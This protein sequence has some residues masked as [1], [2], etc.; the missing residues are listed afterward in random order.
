MVAV[1][2]DVV[3]VGQV[4]AARVDQ[5]D[6]RQVVLV[7]D[8]LR[9]QVLLDGDRV[10]G[11]ALDGGVVTDDH[12]LL[13]FDAADAGDDAGRRRRID[14]IRVLVHAVGGQLRELEEG[15]AGI[16]QH[17]HAVARQ[18]FA[19]GD[20]FGGRCRPAAGGNGRDL[21]EQVVDDGL[22]G[23]RVGLEIVAAGIE[24]AVD[25]RHSYPSF[26][27]RFLLGKAAVQVKPA[28]VLAHEPAHFV[29][30]VGASGDLVTGDKFYGIAI[31]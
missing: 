15:R 25:V 9:A 27:V 7:G 28:T 18:Q 16:E 8:L 19:A 26:L 17:L 3:L 10:V 29:Q 2:E 6:A 1:G 24:L 13:A 23:G 21:G 5:V 12:A 30:A 20:V 22:H 11:A 31:W 14:A 4:G